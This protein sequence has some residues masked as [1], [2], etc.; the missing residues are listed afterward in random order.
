MGRRSRLHATPL[1]LALVAALCL[2]GCRPPA[3]PALRSADPP[4]PRGP[5][6]NI[7]IGVNY[8]DWNNDFGT[9]ASEEALRHLHALGVRHVTYVPTWYQEHAG[10]TNI[11][12]LEGNT[13]DDDALI[14]DMRRARAM[15]FTLGLKLH[16]DLYDSSARSRIAFQDGD[17]FDAWWANYTRIIEHYAVIAR[18]NR[19]E[20]FSVGCE[21]SSVAIPPYTEHWRRLITSVRE[22]LAP[23]G[24]T[25]TYTARH[26]NVANLGFLDALDVIGINA[27]PYF[28]ITPP[29]DLEAVRS[30]W[31]EAM[32]YSESFAGL[33]EDP[34]TYASKGYAM[35]FF[36][37]L[38]WIAA[39]Y[40][41]PV[42]ITEVGCP[43]R[44]G[45]LERPV[46]W[47]T[48]GNPDVY[49]QALFYD[50]FFTELAADA[51]AHRATARTPYPI[52]GVELWNY[53]I[54]EAGPTDTDY[55]FR[56]KPLTETV[57]RKHVEQWRGPGR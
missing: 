8:A 42:V 38:R 57:L 22:T 54:K 18:E 49:A 46:D 44:Q 47:Q 2:A 37:Y 26:Q 24:G 5:A 34:M 30:A 12:R 52:I 21:L 15:G 10:A 9:P 48:R 23:H 33:G 27:W 43:S 16:V 3:P 56:N 45:A 19:V 51:E 1:P 35:D 6:P 31:R 50:G 13:P 7:R 28:E 17:L 25:V 20:L 36:A 53:M 11:H 40:D 4:A 39:L 55:T 41:R 29:V 14:M 32:Y